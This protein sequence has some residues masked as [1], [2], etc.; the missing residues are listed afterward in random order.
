MRTRSPFPF[1]WHRTMQEVHE[2]EWREAEFQ[3][4]PKGRRKQRTDRHRLL[5]MKALLN[6]PPRDCNAPEDAA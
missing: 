4:Q 6:N 2:T 1:L 3:A 5:M